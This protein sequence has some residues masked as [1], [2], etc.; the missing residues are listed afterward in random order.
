MATPNQDFMRA[1]DDLVTCWRESP[2]PSIKISTYFW[3]Y[4]ELFAHLRGT[5]CTFIETGIL[6]GGSLFMWR[7]WL[8]DKARIIGVDLNPEGLKWKEH[9]FEIFI[10][11]QGDPQFWRD[12]LGE[13]GQ[14]D[15]LLDD[16][17]HQ[18]FQQIVTAVE[19]IDHLTQPAV[20]V[21]EDTQSNFMTDFS[22][23]GSH[24][25]LRFAKD[26]SDLMTART[27][28]LYPDRVQGVPNQAMVERYR[29][30]SSVQ[31]FNSLVAF[32][33]VPDMPIQ[34]AV[35]RNRLP[36]SASDFRYNGVTSA[37]VEWP[38]LFNPATVEVRG[39]P[40]KG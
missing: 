2:Y 36:N 32:R 7:R 10:G 14:F 38:Y 29:K 25:F 31:F 16:G 5:E 20:V 19:A 9:G 27:L 24:S 23:Q 15:A 40:T 34:P 28:Q 33:V 8:G 3:A 39:G 13:I 30:L 4:A 12:T 17:G 11:D 37:R 21:V 1:V 18:S 26:L 6:D 35:V 22:S